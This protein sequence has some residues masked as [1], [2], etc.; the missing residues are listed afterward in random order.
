MQLQKKCNLC[1]ILVTEFVA[2]F[3]DAWRLPGN[4]GEGEWRRKYVFYI[5]RKRREA[6]NDTWSR[7]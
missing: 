4:T 3:C 6:W 5:S 7:Y 2:A 1:D